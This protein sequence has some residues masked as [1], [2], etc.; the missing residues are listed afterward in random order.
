MIRNR[1]ESDRIHS[2]QGFFSSLLKSIFYRATEADLETVYK[3]CADVRATGVLFSGQLREDAP[4]GEAIQL[5]RT[6]FRDLTVSSQGDELPNADPLGDFITKV[7][8]DELR[9]VIGTFGGMSRS[10]PNHDEATRSNDYEDAIIEVINKVIAER[11][12]LI[13][14]AQI[15][16]DI[17]RAVTTNIGQMTKSDL[18]NARVLLDR[19]HIDQYGASG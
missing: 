4:D 9:S 13:E 18:D 11:W 17:R 7:L 3:I 10:V 6:V 8:R 2:G 1:I 15:I 12:S 16:T 14:P 19:D 5:R